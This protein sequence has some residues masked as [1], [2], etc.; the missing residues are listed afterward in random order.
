MRAIQASC[1][2]LRRSRCV[3]LLAALAAGLV[4]PVAGA[5]DAGAADAPPVHTATLVRATPTSTWSPGSPDPSGVAWMPGPD[6][7]VVVDSEVEEPTGA[8]WNDANIWFTQ[9]DGTV[10]A[11]GTA[12][13]ANAALFNGTPGYS[14]EPTGVGFDATGSRLFI[15]DDTV[16]RVFVVGAGSDA[17]FGNADDVVAAIDA[18]AFGVTDTEDPVYDP[19]SGNLFILDGTGTEV[20]RVDPVDGVFGN[21]D[22]TVTH[23]DI[24]HLGP[25]DFEGLARDPSRG[26]L[27]V[28]SRI[29][30]QIFE[31]NLDGSLVR[32]I[33]VSG[34]PDLRS[35]SGLEVAPSSV[36]SGSS[37]FIVDRAID[38]GPNPAENDGML[39]EVAAPDLGVFPGASSPTVDVSAMSVMG[40]RTWFGAIAWASVTVRDANNTVV[41]GAKVT[42]TWYQGARVVGSWSGTT[43]SSGVATLWTATLWPPRGTVLTHCVTSLTGTNLTWDTGLFQPTTKTDCAAWTVR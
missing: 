3:G 16:G 22:D 43:S 7:L 34:I 19:V 24:G 1:S 29:T 11:S 20:Y 40:T 18:A 17:V 6:R 28:G 27:Y 8:G 15:S 10:T 33:D 14:P 32:T 38:N 25:T 12:W 9:R 30:K 26:S 13:G 23:F 41:R 36:G 5:A 35:V 21:G 42:G 31:V 39:F 4:A 37:F 2:S